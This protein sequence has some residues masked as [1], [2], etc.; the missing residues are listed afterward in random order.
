MCVSADDAAFGMWEGKLQL[1][2]PG[3]LLALESRSLLESFLEPRQMTKKTKKKKEEKNSHHAA[4]PVSVD[5]SM[6]T[7]ASMTFN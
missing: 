7:C 4:P 3:Q 2:L 1:A 6:S 5:V